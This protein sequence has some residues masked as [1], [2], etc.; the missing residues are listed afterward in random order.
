MI[1]M[2]E[3]LRR[4]VWRLNSLVRQLVCRLQNVGPSPRNLPPADALERA[5]R[6]ALHPVAPSTG[7]RDTLRRN[8]SFAARGRM[9]GLSVEHPK[10]YRPRIVLGVSAGL[11]AATITTVVVLFRL[12]LSHSE[13]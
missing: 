10:A 4:G 6:G 7:F 9:A 5:V 13:G 2:Q 12:R 1:Q 3:V 8:L 11:L